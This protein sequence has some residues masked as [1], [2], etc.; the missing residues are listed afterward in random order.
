MDD[1][2]KDGIERHDARVKTYGA[3]LWYADSKGYKPGYVTAKFKQIYGCFPNGEKAAAVAEAPS[4]E[5]LHWIRRGNAAYA[6]RRRER[7]K[8]E[9]PQIQ[10]PPPAESA[11]MSDDDWGVRL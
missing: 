4:S 6:R 7:E 5:L 10:L 1:S 11:F 3:L 2:D 9:D 8:A